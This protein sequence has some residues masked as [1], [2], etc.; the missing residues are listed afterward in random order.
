MYG[1]NH[2]KQ[3]DKE[4][5]EILKSAVAERMFGVRRFLAQLKAQERY[6]GRGDIRKVVK[7]VGSYGY[8][9]G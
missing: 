6:C 2:N 3:R 4:S 1:K 5:G 7:S 9:A 8:A